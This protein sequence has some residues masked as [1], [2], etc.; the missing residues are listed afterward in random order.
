MAHIEPTGKKK[1][2]TEDVVEQIIHE[3]IPWVAQLVAKITPR[4][5]AENE[6]WKKAQ[7][8]IS[9]GIAQL[10]PDGGAWETID[11][12]R[13]EFFSE[14]RQALEKQDGAGEHA[15]AG[16]G[17]I[18]TAAPRFVQGV[19]ALPQED[20]RQTLEWLAELHAQDAELAAKSV[21]YLND[22]GEREIA[23]FA[24]LDHGDKTAYIEPLF[25]RTDENQ[26]ERLYSSRLWRPVRYATAFFRRT[27][28]Q[29]VRHG[30]GWART[31][32]TGWW[33]NTQRWLTGLAGGFLALLVLGGII[34][35]LGAE[36][37]GRTVILLAGLASI[38]AAL[39]LTVRTAPVLALIGGAAL[40][41]DAATKKNTADAFMKALRTAAS[42]LAW[43]AVVA[44]LCA[45]VPV[46]RSMV[47]FLVV[48]TIG[49]FLFI[50]GFAWQRPPEPV[51][52]LATVVMVL[53][54]VYLTAL[55]LPPVRSSVSRLWDVGGSWTD[56]GLSKIEEV[57]AERKLETDRAKDLATARA[58]AAKELNT[59]KL[60]DYRDALKKR[61]LFI[62]KGLDKL[63]PEETKGYSENEAK[64]NGIETAMY[65][66]P[67][68]S[69]PKSP[70]T[71][72]VLERVLSGAKPDV[73]F[74]K[75]P[76]VARPETAPSDTEKAATGEVDSEA[77]R[78]ALEDIE[79][80]K[81][82]YPELVP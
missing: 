26:F 31:Q 78:K 10:T 50:S 76:P 42:A 72:G 69:A 71:A 28:P 63:T 67:S 66:R 3:V 4:G 38:L 75:T 15:R 82:D 32:L 40:A 47:A 48:L 70:T 20:A 52:K 53:L 46:W 49:F 1:S 11:R 54:G 68:T 30:F 74:K 64:V 8:L 80:L 73:S 35:N 79:S 9:V 62:T 22:L 56:A 55:S 24:K 7:P 33:R 25:G 16:G 14:Y 65:G 43:I 19:L 12:I 21:K 2:L 29:Y 59:V 27:I 51:R 44:A 37:V 45:T 41:A 13:T 60:A 58:E 39:V 5:L 17:E 34:G 23:N 81:R 61:G 57:S 6:I 36:S 18:S 77:V